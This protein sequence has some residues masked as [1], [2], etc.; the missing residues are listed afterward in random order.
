MSEETTETAAE[1][2]GKGLR[3]QLEKTLAENKTLKGREMA[4]SFDDL[5][6]SLDEGLGKAVAKEY[7]GEITTEAI[8]A[9]AKSEY[10]Y[11]A[12]AQA[13][14]HPQAEAIDQGTTQIDAASQG[15]GSV[16]IA[17]TETE[18][19]ASAEAQGD[20]TTAM[21]VKSQQLADMMFKPGR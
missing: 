15:A 17:S 1:E 7:D 16:P 14:Q 12:E 5:G 3:A 21:N 9:Y 10:N 19:L 2:T 4:R 18:V 13:S 11:D 20:Y 6:L 8:A